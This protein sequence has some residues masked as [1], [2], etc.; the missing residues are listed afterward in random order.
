MIVILLRHADRTE[1]DALSPAGERRAKLLA[2]MLAEAGVSVAFRSQFNR[3]AQTLAPLQERLPGLQVKKI[4]F[5]DPHDP[6]GYAA[7]LATAIRALPADAVVAVVG[8]DNSIGPTIARLGGEAIDEIAAAE[9]DKLF[10]LFIG[11]DRANL[12]KLR[13]GDPTPPA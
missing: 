10:V 4:E 5:V 7:T 9:F 12:L 6:D 13:Y 11:P 8:H 3:T 1:A 2:R